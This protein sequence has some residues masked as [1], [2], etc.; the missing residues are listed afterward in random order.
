MKDL[1]LYL[2]ISLMIGFLIGEKQACPKGKYSYDY[3]CV[4]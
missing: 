1:L 3:G 4:Q 2:L